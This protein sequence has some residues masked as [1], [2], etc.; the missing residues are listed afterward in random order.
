MNN[1]TVYVH[2]FP[3]GKKYVGITSRN[4][5]YRWR[6]GNGYKGQPIVWNAIQKYGWHNIEHNILYKN[7]TE[8]EA[9]NIEIQ[10]IEDWNTINP[11]YGY[12]ASKGGDLG[13]LGLH[14]SNEVKEKCRQAAL[15]QTPPWL[16]KTLTEE[17]KQH[18]RD[19]KPCKAVMCLE[20]GKIYQSLNLAAQDT[21][22]LAVNISKCCRGL[23]KEPKSGLHWTFVRESG[24][25]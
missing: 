18:I 15:K 16:G 19:K 2:I 20:T 8:E 24:D 7:L 10:L 14:H 13:L 12:N 11:M 6:N 17:H 3:N 1:Y 23:V 4:T 21:G 25:K 5:K 22:I 9:I